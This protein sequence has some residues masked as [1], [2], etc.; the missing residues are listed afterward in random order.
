MLARHHDPR[1][2]P[3]ELWDVIVDGVPL[4]HVPRGPGFGAALARAVERLAAGVA[5][6][7][8]GGEFPAA[9]REITEVVLVGG[10]AGDVLWDSPKI[11]AVPASEPERCAER[12]GRAILAR[13]GVRGLVVDLGQSRLKV[14]GE[15]QRWTHPRDLAAVPISMR[16]VEGVGRAA[17]VAFVAGALREAAADAR[18]EAIVLALPCEVASDGALGTCSYPWRAGE[19]VVAEMLTAAGL[20]DVP[21][22]LVNDAEL[23][24][25]GVAQDRP[26]GATTLVLT[27]G[28]GVG[29]ALVRP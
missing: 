12:G 18:P 10:A 6:S 8:S 2:T 19:A 14:W 25:V 29:G 3:I 13:A 4:Y 28:F 7:E 21:T 16:P 11:P 17:L 1:V 23:A 20:A 15:R 27:L 5:V 22:W 24:A 26:A 9:C